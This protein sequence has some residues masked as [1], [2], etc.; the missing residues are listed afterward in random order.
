MLIALLLLAALAAPAAGQGLGGSIQDQAVTL[1]YPATHW[2][3]SA[4]ADLLGAYPAPTDD[5]L[6]AAGWWYRVDGVDSRE[7]PFPPPDS[8]TYEDGRLT[9]VWNNVD[10][11][12]FRATEVTHV[13]DN[14]RPS[15][16]VLTK[17]SLE[18]LTAGELGVILFRYVDV[19]LPGNG[20]DDN[21][22]EV[23][24]ANTLYD[25]TELSFYSALGG[26]AVRY[27]PETGAGASVR[28]RV[29]AAGDLLAALND[30]G[31][32]S[33]ADDGPPYGPGD[34]AVGHQW[35]L[36]L[37]PGQ[38]LHVNDALSVRPRATYIKG[39]GWLRTGFPALLLRQLAPPDPYH[40][41]VAWDMR[42]TTRIDT[43]SIP[44]PVP[45]RGRVVGADDFD[46]D[47]RTDLVEFNAASGLTYIH[48]EAVTGALPTPLGWNI[49][50]TGDFDLDGNPD[51]VWRSALTRKIVIWRMDDTHKLGDIVPVPDQASDANWAIAA[52]LD[53]NGDGRRDL[54]WYNSTSGNAVIWYMDAQV[55]RI[56]GTFTSPA[57]AG[58]NNWRIV[59]AG[60]YGKGPSVAG[61]PA[62]V[63]RAPDI[64]WRNATSGKFVVWHMD[65][66]G[67]RTAG[68]FTSPDGP[69]DP[70]GYEVVGP[71]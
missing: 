65:L 16:T 57:S 43:E 30:A 68:V 49:E 17:L 66:A 24:A 31:L 20:D 41:L 19:D 9:L 53:F 39:E 8:E 37:H 28:Y 18:N 58:N 42:R 50:A 35:T 23:S 40:A 27:R 26:G 4:K 38:A 62:P 54:L 34:A 32:T 59:A 25:P 55:K 5:P 69:E 46:H 13:I 70:L 22:V 2:S 52:A 67:Q 47:L 3:A 48:G 61:A 45:P 1:T 11:R 64:V 15:G 6:D 10:G 36:F 7:R 21:V 33:Y 71:R 14:E 51:L 29:G 56:Q 12:G 60:N 63:D 44:T